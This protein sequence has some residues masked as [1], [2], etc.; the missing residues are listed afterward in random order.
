MFRIIAELIWTIW[1]IFYHIWSL[2]CF[3]FW[4]IQNH[5]CQ[6]FC[7]KLRP[8][9]VLSIRLC[10]Q[11]M[12]F[13]SQLDRLHFS[14]ITELQFTWHSWVSFISFEKIRP[15][16]GRN[17]FFDK[18]SKEKNIKYVSSNRLTY[19]HT[20]YW[21]FWSY[22]FLEIKIHAPAFQQSQETVLLM[23]NNDDLLLLWNKIRKT[24]ICSKTLGNSKLVWQRCH[25][26]VTGNG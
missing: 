22:T 9:L 6:R 4:R 25:I 26:V 14:C 7:L 18:N 20:M 10:M 16:F 13:P 21:W 15:I 8:L 24:L 3:M 11:S 17:A 19:L 2:D 5:W 23:N 1:K 12:W